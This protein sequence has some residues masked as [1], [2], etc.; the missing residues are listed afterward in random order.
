MS[1]TIVVF[2][3]NAPTFYFPQT[4]YVWKPSKQLDGFTYRIHIEKM[5]NES[6]MDIGN[7]FA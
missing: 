3:S 2:E 6:Q 4:F 7:D 1:A 5:N